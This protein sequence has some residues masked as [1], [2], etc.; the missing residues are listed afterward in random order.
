MATGQHLSH[1][2][3]H[4]VVAG[5]IKR[6]AT[7]RH[8][9]IRQWVAK[10]TSRH[11]DLRLTTSTSSRTGDGC[12][13]CSRGV[14]LKLTTCRPHTSA[15]AAAACGTSNAPTSITTAAAASAAQ[16]AVSAQRCRIPPWSLPALNTIIAHLQ[17]CSAAVCPRLR[18]TERRLV[19]D[20][21]EDTTLF[22][23]IRMLCSNHLC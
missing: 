16:K 12:G 8:T 15:A 6:A 3:Q 23:Q 13:N 7:N 9:R 11:V 5:G 10:P 4:A 21:D 19:N 1:S 17:P 22:E 20:G 18:R 14:R 2:S